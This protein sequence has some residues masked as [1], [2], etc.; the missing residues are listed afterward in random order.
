MPT[1]ATRRTTAVGATG[2]ICIDVED[3]HRNGADYVDADQGV[4]PAGTVGRK[5]LAGRRDVDSTALPNGRLQYRCVSAECWTNEE[6]GGGAVA[7][8]S[9]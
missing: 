5:A 9:R 7:Q 3:D 8:I 1:V 4:T 2:R 6:G